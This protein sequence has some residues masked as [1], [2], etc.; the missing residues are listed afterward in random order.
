MLVDF[1]VIE[2]AQTRGLPEV[3]FQSIISRE[4]REQAL[5]LP[6]I[7]SALQTLNQEKDSV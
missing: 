3:N 2:H 4:C 7:M 6:L 1:F 5:Y